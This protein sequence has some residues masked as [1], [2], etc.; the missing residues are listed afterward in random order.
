VRLQGTSPGGQYAAPFNGVVTAWSIQAGPTPAPVRFKVA[1]PEFGNT[2][3]ILGESDQKTLAPSQLNVFT[4]I[5]VP[6]QAGDVIG[7][8][9][10]ATE[11]CNRVVPGGGYQENPRFGDVAPGSM[12]SFDADV[13]NENQLNLAAIVEPDCDSDGFGDETQ[14]SDLSACRARTVS[15]DANKNKVKK[16]KKV[17]LAGQIV[18]GALNTSGCAANQAVELQRKKPSQ[19][20]FATVEQLQTEAAG[21]FSTK[22]KVKKTFEYRAEVLETA[23]CAGQASNTEKVKAKKPN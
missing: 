4:D 22:Q 9:L 16:G 7:F 23:T 18:D 6:V 17:T 2:F 19:A 5:R 13:P 12:A 3:T 1:H 15:L 20:E 8:Y 21:A 10:A 14:D 11:E